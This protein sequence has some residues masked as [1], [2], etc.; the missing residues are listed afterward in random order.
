MTLIFAQQQAQPP[1]ATFRLIKPEHEADSWEKLAF[2][3]QFKAQNL[4]H[5]CNVSL[6]TLQ[7]YFAKNYNCTVTDWLRS[8]RLDAAY[9]RLKSGDRVKEVAIDL[10]YKQL[11]HFSREFKR[12]HGIAPSYLNAG[13]TSVERTLFQL[14]N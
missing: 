11:S 4:A 12:Q 13:I 14:Q 1:V 6:R 2:K 5:L 9:R 3:A 8:I 10:H 7:R